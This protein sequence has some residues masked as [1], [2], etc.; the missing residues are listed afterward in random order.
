MDTAAGRSSES[1]ES[2]V[3]VLVA[4]AI[5]AIAAVAV[6]AG[7][8]LSVQASDMHR[9]Q[10]TGSAYVRSYAEAIER[11]LDAGANYTPCAA[12]DAYNVPAVTDRVASL[13][14]GFSLHHTAAVPLGGNGAALSG[15]SCADQGVQRLRLEVASA[16]GRAAET[17]TVVLRRPCGT[18]SSCS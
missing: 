2:L 10:S 16:D 7:L 15:G 8:Q 17:L 3:E 9:K 12:A 1:G 14:A 5:L 11:Y 18:G 4:V 13:P 6:L